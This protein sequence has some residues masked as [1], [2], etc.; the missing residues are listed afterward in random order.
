MVYRLQISHQN[1]CSCTAELIVSPCDWPRMVT[2]G[3][4]VASAVVTQQGHVR[5]RLRWDE[6][7]GGTGTDT[8][9]SPAP[10]LLHVD[11]SILTSTGETVSWRQVYRKRQ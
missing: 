6:P 7:L 10:G 11:S 3:Q 9:H 8:F 5:L 4:H 2:A 1:K